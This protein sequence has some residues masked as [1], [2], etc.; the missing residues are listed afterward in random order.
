M[1]HKDN[2]RFLYTE[3]KACLI[4]EF[5]D[6]FIRDDTYKSY[7]GKCTNQQKDIIEY[8]SENFE[9][10]K[11]SRSEVQQNVNERVEKFYGMF[12]YYGWT[13]KQTKNL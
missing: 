5:N 11:E 3:Y 2:L 13:G 9:K 12:D 7:K 8:L 1:Y 10:V 6:Y 4:K